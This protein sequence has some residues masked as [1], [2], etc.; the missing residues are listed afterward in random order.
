VNEPNSQYFYCANDSTLAYVDA[1]RI[2]ADSIRAV[3]EE[4]V[5]I[6]GS[7][8]PAPVSESVLREEYNL[9]FDQISAIDWLS[10]IYEHVFPDFPERNIPTKDYFDVVGYH[11]YSRQCF[12][13]PD[14][15]IT[16]CG[17]MSNNGFGGPLI[18]YDGN[19]SSPHSRWSTFL[20]TRTLYDVMV[21]HGDSLKQIWGTEVGSQTWNDTATVVQAAWVNDYMKQWFDWPFTGPLMW[22]CVRDPSQIGINMSTYGLFKFNWEKKQSY[23]EMK[24]WASGRVEYHIGD[25]PFDFAYQQ[26]DVD[27]NQDGTS[28]FV[29]RILSSAAICDTLSIFFHETAQPYDLSTLSLLDFTL[30]PEASPFRCLELVGCGPDRSDRDGHFVVDGMMGSIKLRANQALKVKNLTFRNCQSS[31]HSLFTSLG[32]VEIENCRF[33]SNHY[34]QGILG[35]GDANL[36]DISIRN[37]QL[38][39]IHGSIFSGNT[40]QNGIDE[41]ALIN[42]INGIFVTHCTFNEN[43]FTNG[44]IRLREGLAL[45]SNSL[46]KS[47]GD[48]NGVVIGNLSANLTVQYCVFNQED[49]AASFLPTV[50]AVDNVIVNHD[51]SSDR[52]AFVNPTAG[53]FRL[54]WDNVALDKADPSLPLDFDLTRAD[55]GWQAETEVHDLSGDV[56]EALEEGHYNVTDH[57][58][59]HVPLEAGVVL[60]VASGK[61]VLFWPGAESVF[62]LGSLDGPRTAIV[63]RPAP[64]LPSASCIEFF[65]GSNPDCTYEFN[66]VMFNYPPI[67]GTTSYLYFTGYDAG[68]L[69][70]GRQV[71]FQNWINVA[72]NNGSGTVV[73]GGLMLEG[74][75]GQVSHLSVG[76]PSGLGPGTLVLNNSDVNVRHCTFQETGSNVTWDSPPLIVSSAYGA[77]TPQLTH[78]T[79]LGTASQVGS[80]ADLQYTVLRLEHNR[81]LDCRTTAL[82]ETHASLSMGYEARNDFMANP[83]SFQPN[84]A[85]L[86]LEG[87]SLDMYCGRNNVVVSDYD[88]GWPIITW[89]PYPGDNPVPQVWRQNFWG[90]TCSLPIPESALNDSTLSLLPLWATAEGSLLSCVELDAPQNPACPFEPYAAHELLALGNQAELAGNHALARDY[91]RFLLTLHA[92]SREANESTLRLKAL[93]LHKDYGPGA[94]DIVAGDLFTAADSSEAVPLH[95]QAVLQVCGGW[96]VEARWGDRLGAKLALNALLALETD[97]VCRD[98]IERAL[99]EIDTYPPQGG[100]SAA[101][102]EAQVQRRLARQEALHA[103]L[104][105]PRGGHA[106]RSESPPRP[107]R[108]HLQAPYPNPFNPTTTLVVDVPD[109]GEVR[110]RIYNLAGQQVAEALHRQLPAGR[111][112]VQVDGGGW[113]SGVYLAVAECAGHSQVQ[114]VVLL[115]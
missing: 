51:Q 49:W 46:F 92:A 67:N 90:T 62:P 6:L 89:S 39:Q 50:T 33:I 78:N 47:V 36:G 44:N 20:T 37:T 108:F 103:L 14:S 109:A 12:T 99:L 56:T 68:V 91:Y 106:E 75:T 57:S 41:L 105:Y 63:G 34:P 3:D 60:R 77:S 1:L 15:V 97:K 76:N 96:C 29:E 28:D 85:L 72:A 40:P 102:P 104:S 10:S 71:Q 65:P 115:K 24:N 8:L 35:W 59:I 23:D 53:D 17:A 43:M 88:E 69:L 61:S 81:F 73:D 25:S 7:M 66:G 5:I 98:T 54:R 18:D 52:L 107:E 30:L 101:G 70:D 19:Q 79:F 86:S 84:S 64:G 55:I 32:D 93:G 58:T 83:T 110:V 26:W 95:Q 21:E 27:L 45:V 94:Y 112:R 38:V 113:A 48:G 114:K 100:L 4:A 42:C 2:A 11:P 31:V 74:M 80:L 9:S 111:H 13:I 82:I 87:G 16:N 22:F